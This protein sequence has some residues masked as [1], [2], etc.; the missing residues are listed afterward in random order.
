MDAQA[1]PININEQPLIA[2]EVEPPA[3]TMILDDDNSSS[4]NKEPM[5]SEPDAIA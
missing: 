4:S 5:P 3:M 2:D 1:L